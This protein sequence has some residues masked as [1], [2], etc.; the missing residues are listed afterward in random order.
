MLAAMYASPCTK[1]FGPRAFFGA[2]EPARC[3]D[4]GNAMRE[5]FYPDGRDL[6]TGWRLPA[7]PQA[8]YN[9]PLL[10]TR[11]LSSTSACTPCPWLFV[12]SLSLTRQLGRCHRHV[13]A[14]VTP[15]NPAVK[16]WG[17]FSTALF[18][19]RQRISASQF[20]APRSRQS[21]RRRRAKRGR[22]IYIYIDIYMPCV[23]RFDQ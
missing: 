17:Q 13:A 14:D 19:C 3:F 2:L 8:R 11:T 12:I 6:A 18:R 22:T 21:T 20:S 23:P 15:T 7:F 4:D 1:I 9:T 16:P 5:I 10:S